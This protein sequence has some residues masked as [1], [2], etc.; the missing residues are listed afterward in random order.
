MEQDLSGYK[1]EKEKKKINKLIDELDLEIKE[2]Q[3][4][5]NGEYEIIDRIVKSL[6]KRMI[7]NND[8]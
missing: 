5:Y 3:T 1:L 6:K 4:F 2:H 7:K 8:F